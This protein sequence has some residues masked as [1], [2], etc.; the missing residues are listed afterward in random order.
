MKSNSISPS[1]TSKLEQIKQYMSKGRVTAFVGAGFS[2]NAEMP[3]HV[4]MKTWAQLRDDFLTKLYGNDEEAKS[5]DQNDVVQLAS[6]IDAE[7]KRNELDEI[8]EAALPDKLIRPGVLH[9]KLVKLPWRDILTTNYDTLLERAAE[10]EVQKYQL[11]TNKETLLYQP[12][13]RIIKLHGSFPNI[14]PYIM[15]REDYRRYPL[16]HPEM[17]NTAR[18][19]FLESLMC[20]IG[21]SGDDPNFQSWLG[22]LRDVIGKDRICPT[23][24]VTYKQGYHD[25]EKSLM[26]KLGIDIINL[27]EIPELKNFKQAYNFFLDYMKDSRSRR[28]WSGRVSAFDYHI[29]KG[30]EKKGIETLVEEMSHIRKTYPGWIV[31]P[32][33]Y[34]DQFRD[35]SEKVLFL[36]RVF[37]HLS[38][39]WHLKLRLL[40]ELDWRMSISCTPKDIEW[41]VPKINEAI[42]H[43][44]VPDEEDRKMINELRLSL[45]QIY[46]LKHNKENFD[47]VCKLLIADNVNVPIGYVKYQQILFAQVTL[48]YK[49][50]QQCLSDWPTDYGDYLDCIHKASVLQ[51]MGNPRD[52]FDILDKCRLMLSK[53]WVHQGNDAYNSSCL[54][55]VLELMRYSPINVGKI[56]IPE[57]L[58]QGYTLADQNVYCCK[59]T[60]ERHP[61]HGKKVVHNFKLGSYSNT[62][63][64]GPGGFVIDYLYSQRWFALKEKVGM[65]FYVVDEKFH[66][67]CI[68]R[69]FSYDWRFA[70]D[71]LLAV[72]NGIF[73]KEILN[74]RCLSL[75]SKEE[76]NEYF[77][78]YIGYLDIYE[79]I[80][81]TH[82]KGVVRYNL[83]RMLGRLC[84]V[85]T[86][87]R[88]MRYVKILI[89][90]DVR[91]VSEI[92][93]F[94]YD[95]LPAEKISLLMP[96]VLEKFDVKTPYDSGIPLP[97][98]RNNLYFPV[99][100]SL[101]AKVCDGFS[102]KELKRQSEAYTLCLF[103][104]KDKALG[105][106]DKKHF[107]NAIRK[108]RA[109]TES[110]DIHYSY[111]L[112][113]A[114]D[115]ELPRLKA[116][117][118]KAVD[119]F[120]GEDY[121]YNGSSDILSLC[122]SN[123]EKV[124]IYDGRLTD[125]QV[126]KVFCKIV[127]IIHQNL[128][129]FSGE[130]ENEMFFGGLR[131]FLDDIMSCVS[132]F[133]CKHCQDFVSNECLDMFCSD[134]QV[135][136]DNGY[137]CLPMLVCFTSCKDTLSMSDDMNEKL[138][139]C[140][141]SKEPSM[142]E[143][144]VSA[145][146][147]AWKLGYDIRD[148]LN[149]M[150]SVLKVIIDV[151][152]VH[153]LMLI[154][155]LMLKGFDSDLDFCSKVS[156]LLTQ[157]YDNINEFEL[158]TDE[159]IEVCYHANFVAGIASIM[160][161]DVQFQVTLDFP[162]FNYEE[163][164]FNDVYLGYERGIEEAMELKEK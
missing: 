123:L 77:D 22:W 115:E 116:W 45:L 85:V 103:L 36:G 46:R 25:A 149:H 33:K 132:D 84:A 3:S 57:H 9:R 78:E 124:C 15:T 38:D 70:W 72:A 26:A 131:T 63:S 5:K 122:S 161:K 41:Y 104:W 48:N 6:L 29:N 62:W 12:S 90:F 16:E 75:I 147:F 92:L 34:Y 139:K 112:L 42:E 60:Y 109:A 119:D 58:K 47:E 32:T 59:N 153:C 152:M 146:L 79:E 27:A 35:A 51:M 162:Y 89:K 164:G 66:Q 140:L 126:Q 97:S 37:N 68:E 142:R 128:S 130:N 14:R 49:S 107:E 150:F 145:I 143:Q 61:E 118:L 159:K 23:Y 24:L 87:D 69:M 30:E 135:I 18:Q 13:P 114:N 98:N 113:E 67:Y 94:I 95:F 50:I 141:F 39:E 53:T 129:A 156:N 155:S 136:L 28:D 138:K 81:N 127:D 100:S 71:K 83:V 31:L 151:R 65:T 157:I 125:E 11:V 40:Y 10:E 54:V 88:V 117:V 108:W 52:A 64:M 8:L 111:N 134:L 1:L 55:Y 19:A 148:I 74:R 106:E 133:V 120:C 73:V 93:C 163:S 154:E 82:Q 7:F 137:R 110:T 80:I 158:D 160:Y 76:A 102:S 43:I 86:E 21:F 96:T 144:T 101:L 44:D 20:L 121:V 91:T 56:N 99:D 105:S 4:Q 2:L 17:V